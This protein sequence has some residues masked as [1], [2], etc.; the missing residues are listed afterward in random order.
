MS[1]L[2]QPVPLFPILSGY[3]MGILNHFMDKSMEIEIVSREDRP[4]WLIFGLYV[5]LGSDLN[6]VK[7]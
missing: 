2:M 7:K 5:C 6:F 1:Y 3:T 4:D